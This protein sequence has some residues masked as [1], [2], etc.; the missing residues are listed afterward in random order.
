MKT[1]KYVIYQE[2]KYFVSQGLNIDVASCGDTM[3]EAVSNL[4]EAVELYQSI[5]NA[6]LGETLINV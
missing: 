3:E 2:G 4:K 5:E 1:L 6:A